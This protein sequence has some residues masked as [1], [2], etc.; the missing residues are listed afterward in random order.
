VIW[1]TGY[2]RSYPWL[3]VP[4]L[5]AHGEIRQHRGVTPVPGLYVLGQR[6]QHF[7]S[8]NF[9]DGVGRDAAFVVDHLARRD[10][11]VHRC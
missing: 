6:F 2:R 3:H 1:A 4:V 10:A 11:P 9:I 8:S 7:R 5:D